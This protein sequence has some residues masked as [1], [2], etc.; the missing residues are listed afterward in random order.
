MKKNKGGA[1]N[2]KSAITFIAPAFIF[3]FIFVVLPWISAIFF[4]FFSWD[5]IGSAV[6]NSYRNYLNVFKDPEQL[7]SI[8]NSISLIFFFSLI[9]VF[10]GL[11]SAS[12]IS[13]MKSKSQI[14]R[15]SRLIIFIPQVLPLIAVGIAWKL[16]FSPNGLINQSLNLIG[17]TKFQHGWLG[18]FN[19][20]IKAIGI[21]G[22]WLGTGLCSLLFSA[23]I[24]KIDSH[25]YESIQID[26][27]GKIIEF[28]NVTLPSLRPEIRFAITITMISALSGFDLVYV[29]TNGGP[30]GR[31]LVPGLEV[32]RLAF[33]YQ[34][35]GQACALAV[36]LSL[37]TF[38]FILLVAKLLKDY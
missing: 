10:L 27:G 6:W 3:Y 37:I 8:K 12:V 32:F 9:P 1:S 17:L 38:S 26:G 11:V 33:T 31:T 35:F 20:A 2:F 25:L 28:F 30:G 22:V 16:I 19:F 21:V 15:L 34:Q 4:S 24:Q 18:D 5:G 29:M 36:I 14:A 7:R 23:G 13:D